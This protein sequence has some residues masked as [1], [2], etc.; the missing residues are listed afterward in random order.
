MKT[1]YISGQMAGI[2]DYNYPKFDEVEN[3]LLNQGHT[4]VNPANIARGIEFPKGL[5]DEEKYPIFMEEDIKSLTSCNSIFL[6]KGWENSKGAKIELKVAL[7]LKIEI[8][9]E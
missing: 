6:L 9:L 5:T 3:E 4:V 1:V 7:D 2:K 8:I